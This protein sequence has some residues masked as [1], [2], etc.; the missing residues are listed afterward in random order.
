MRGRAALFLHL[1]WC[2]PAF[3]TYGTPRWISVVGLFCSVSLL[4]LLPCMLV[5]L[6][7]ISLVLKDLSKKFVRLDSNNWNG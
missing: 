6:W 3:A 7:K 1:C 4:V 5:I 2:T